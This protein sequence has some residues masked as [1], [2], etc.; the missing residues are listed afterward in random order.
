[1]QACKFFMHETLYSRLS[2]LHTAVTMT[3][4]LLIPN[5]SYTRKDFP[6]QAFRCSYAMSAN[7]PF[8]ERSFR[9]FPCSPQ[10]HLK[11]CSG[12][13]RALSRRG[14]Q[15]AIASMSESNGRV[16]CLSANVNQ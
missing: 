15:R 4:R 3:F 11:I 14:Q 8:S 16:R 13:A 2:N 7:A 12:F 9:L 6:P 10:R 5:P 1:M